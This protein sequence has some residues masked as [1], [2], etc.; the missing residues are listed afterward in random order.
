M[1]DR[2]VPPTDADGKP[3]TGSMADVNSV[4]PT[5]LIADAHRAGLFVHSFTFRDETRYLPGLYGGDPKQELVQ[6][7]AAGIDGVFADFANTA[8]AAPRLPGAKRAVIRPG[9]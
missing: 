3:F 6:F 8:V 9:P 7:F 2:A 4:A 1:A 5:S